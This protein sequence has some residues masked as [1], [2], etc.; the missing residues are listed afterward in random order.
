MADFAL[1]GVLK[2]IAKFHESESIK[3][4]SAQMGE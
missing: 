1:N 2:M 3:S 4:L